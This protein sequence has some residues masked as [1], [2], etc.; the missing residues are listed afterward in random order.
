[1]PGSSVSGWYAAV[2]DCEL[3]RS[4]VIRQPA[5]TAS[6]AAYLLAGGWLLA[7]SERAWSAPH[8]YRLLAAAVAA[9]GVGS[10]LYHGPGWP[11]SGWCHDVAAL[12]VP[13]FVAADGL[14]GIR[15]WDDRG[16]TR[17]YLTVVAATGAAL[18]ALPVTNPALLTAV[19]TAVLAETAVARRPAAP[20]RASPDRTGPARRRGRVARV[21]MLAALAVG[22][23]AY[24]AGRTGGPLCRPDSLLQPHALWHL[25][26]AVAMAAWATHRIA[27]PVQPPAPPSRGNRHT[28]AV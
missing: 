23:A 15:G 27:Y 7:Q 12:A 5:N 25:L 11:G 28:P 18:L 24:L 14:G 6:A 17:G 26:T 22:A 20:A 13:V 2:G 4:G 21:V 19:A 9:N 3:V 16:I 8:R 10:G 1:M